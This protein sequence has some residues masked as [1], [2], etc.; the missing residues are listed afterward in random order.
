M[1]VASNESVSGPCT[2]IKVLDF[3]TMVSGPLCSQNL[4]DLGA[5]VIKVEPPIGDT[6]RYLGGVEREGLSGFFAQLNRN[7]RAMVIDLGKPDGQALA[8]E[9]AQ[10]VDVV[11]ENFR[12]G[13]AE[14]LGIDYE[15]L[16]Q[17][18]PGLVYVSI[19]GF[20]QDGPY[21][22]FPTYDLV[23]QGLS[24]V[25]PI[26]GSDEQPKMMQTVVVDKCVAITAASATLAALLARE[27]NNG[28]GQHVSVPMLD[29][30]AQLMLTDLM[31][32][33]SF[34]PA[35]AP[36]NPTIDLYRTWKTQDGHVVGI[37][38]EDH[39][40][41]G[42]CRVLD[43]EQLT[44]DERFVDIGARFANLPALMALLEVE[45]EKWPTEPLIAA[46]RE[47]DVP[48]APV[49]SV[50]DFLADPQ[51][52]HNGIVLDADD[53]QGGMARYISHPSHYEKTPA[54]LYRHPPRLA[55]H[56]AEIL[57]QFGIGS[58]RIA[59]LVDAGVI[60]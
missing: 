29:A 40:F 5:D 58:E 50:A 55:E 45:I 38:I 37:V 56:S 18:N 12:P 34:Q 15:R 6:S 31:T 25:M 43:C 19:S 22:G 11:I 41:S 27:R 60:R 49:Y 23:I 16:K 59:S 42:L 36:P 1:K 8:R 21:A 13:V 33:Q 52:A 14:R 46:L 17:D 9:I 20:G 44:R 4:G 51:V 7:K 35:D 57:A 2:G 47:A 53:P 10:G 48:F 39:Q 30:Y 32:T 28:L 24:G 3:T 54:Q 26:Q